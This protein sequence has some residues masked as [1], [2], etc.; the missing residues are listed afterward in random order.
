MPFAA[1]ERGQPEPG[2]GS[3]ELAIV[4]RAERE[5]RPHVDDARSIAL[6]AIGARGPA[7][8][9]PEGAQLGEHR[10][11]AD[12]RSALEALSRGE[13]RH[14]GHPTRGGAPKSL[15]SV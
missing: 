3:L 1:T 2:E 12:T 14:A 10:I 8:I 11:D 15:Y 9:V 4:M 6:H 5:I 13:G 7:D